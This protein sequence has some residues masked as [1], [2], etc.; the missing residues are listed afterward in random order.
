[1]SVMSG[2]VHL[3]RTGRAMKSERGINDLA[4]KQIVA[5]RA[6]SHLGALALNCSGAAT[7]NA[8]RKAPQPQRK[9]PQ[10]TQ[11]GYPEKGTE[12]STKLAGE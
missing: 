1:M 8:D 12:L 4:A 5:R 9:C 2:G 3:S 10:S 11:S 7:P 6:F